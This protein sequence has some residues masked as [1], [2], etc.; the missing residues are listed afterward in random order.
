M[1]RPVLGVVAWALLLT[2]AAVTAQSLYLPAK[3]WLAMQ[4]IA[5]A[6]AR[7]PGSRP[8]P[9][10]DFRAV[11]RLRVPRLALDQIVLD[12]ASPRA[13]AFGPGLV[14]R[15]PGAGPIVSAH[16]DTHFSWIGR[17]RRG[18]ELH[19]EQGGVARRYRV[20]SFAVVN[21]A[22]HALAAV[23]DDILVLTTCWPL[24]AITA[25]GDLRYVI[26]AVAMP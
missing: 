2:G 5:D 23:P 13:L 18:D 20:A 17:L 10:A 11:A 24:D 15:Q 3:G 12:Q 26:T 8:W 14:R 9:Q 19:W 21:S 22:E 6:Y 4:L 1:K 16:R 25:G 7:A